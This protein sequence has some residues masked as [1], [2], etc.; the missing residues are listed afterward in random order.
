MAMIIPLSRPAGNPAPADSMECT[1]RLKEKTM[2]LL[3]ALRE[4]GVRSLWDDPFRAMERHFYKLMRRFS[5]EGGM[6]EGFGIYPVDI[7]EDDDKVYIEAELP[8]FDKD[9][10]DVSLESG[11]LTI[12]AERKVEP[13]KRTHHLTERRFT[14]VR[15]SFSLPGTVEEAQVEATLD[16]G[17]LQI[18]L[19]KGEERKRR[20]IEVK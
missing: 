8:G 1:S 17:V 7:S 13:T 20:K 5:E 16:G 19:E 18:T 14:Q 2:A 15:R 12:T 9:E 4:T 10:I 6:E 11:V 3:P